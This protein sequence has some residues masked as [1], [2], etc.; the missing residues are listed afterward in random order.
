MLLGEDVARSEVRRAGVLPGCSQS[1]FGGSPGRC[2]AVGGERAAALPV[3][4]WLAHALAETED[5]TARTV[6]RCPRRAC[7]TGRRQAYCWP[8]RPGSRCSAWPPPSSGVVAAAGHG[9]DRWPARR[10]ARHLACGITGAAVGV[11]IRAAGVPQPEISAAVCPDLPGGHRDEPW[12]PRPGRPA[13][14]LGGGR[15]GLGPSATCCSRSWSRS[16]RSR[17]SCDVWSWAGS[18]PGG[19]A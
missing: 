1:L 12:L 4:A 6:T 11:G 7:Y 5:D 19:N 9:D 10:P 15:G 13:A 8:R 17:S 2:E 14:W 3:S 16:P 18:R